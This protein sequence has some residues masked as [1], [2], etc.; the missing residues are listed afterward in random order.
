MRYMCVYFIYIRHKTRKFYLLMHIRDFHE[1]GKN[2]Q[3]IL[4]YMLTKEQLFLD[5]IYLCQRSRLL[6]INKTYFFDLIILNKNSKN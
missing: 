2:S 1:E 3:G 4:F 6:I 5:F